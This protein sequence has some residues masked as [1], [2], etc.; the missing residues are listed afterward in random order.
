MKDKWTAPD[1]DVGLK[2]P[3]T[4]LQFSYWHKHTV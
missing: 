3:V 1:S 4:W 2:H